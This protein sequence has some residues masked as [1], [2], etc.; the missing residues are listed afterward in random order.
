MKKKRLTA[1]EVFFESLYFLVITYT[2]SSMAAS[3][4]PRLISLLFRVTNVFAFAKFYESIQKHT[5]ST[6]WTYVILFANLAAF[7]LLA[8]KVGYI[9]GEFTPSPGCIKEVIY[10]NRT[11]LKISAESH[12]C[13]YSADTGEDPV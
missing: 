8:R 3:F 7:A 13:L 2:L 11:D 4:N 5:N 10:E 1:I 9:K 12:R 6:F